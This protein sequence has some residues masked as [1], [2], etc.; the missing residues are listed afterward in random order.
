[1]KDKLEELEKKHNKSWILLVEEELR[2]AEA[3]AE[4]DRDNEDTG[5]E[6]TEKVWE[7]PQISREDTVVE[8]GLK[9]LFPVTQAEC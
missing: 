2:K 4:V 7:E 8:G 6:I 1:M 3:E 5:D 9:D